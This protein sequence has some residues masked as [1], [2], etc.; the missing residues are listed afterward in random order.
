MSSCIP[1]NVPADA[2]SYDW[3]VVKG[4]GIVQGTVRLGAR[5]VNLPFSD[6]MPGSRA[7][8]PTRRV[9]QQ[10]DVLTFLGRQH[11]WPAPPKW[12]VYPPGE[13]AFAPGRALAVATVTVRRGA[14]TVSVAE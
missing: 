3:Y 1:H 5:A 6:R 11:R 8:V 13:T 9:E 4:T 2:V 10:N 12:A 7:R 14:F